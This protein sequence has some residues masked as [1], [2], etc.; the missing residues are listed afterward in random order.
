MSLSIL[1]LLKILEIIDWVLQKWTIHRGIQRNN[2]PVGL[3]GASGED[4]LKVET[5][6]IF[7]PRIIFITL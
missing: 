5:V 7:A 6:N 2:S 1:T 3:A 4:N